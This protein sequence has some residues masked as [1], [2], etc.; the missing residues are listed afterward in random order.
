MATSTQE[1]NDHISPTIGID[2]YMVVVTNN[3]LIE[4][5][6]TILSQTIIRGIYSFSN[7]KEARRLTSQVNFDRDEPIAYMFAK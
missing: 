6:D 1:Y 5:S 3:V 2:K 7:K 4:T